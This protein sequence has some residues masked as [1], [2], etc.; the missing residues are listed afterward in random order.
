MYRRNLLKSLLALGGL[1]LSIIPLKARSVGASVVEPVVTHTLNN[2]DWLNETYVYR[3]F[4]VGWTGW[5]PS[6]HDFSIGGSKLVGQWIA[7]KHGSHPIWIYSS[8]PGASGVYK[9]GD[10]FD[11]TRKPWQFGTYVF[12]NRF[13]NILEFEK[14]KAKEIIELEIDFYLQPK[15]VFYYRKN[16]NTFTIQE[17]G[18]RVQH[19]LEGVE[20][21]SSV[22][23]CY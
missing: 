22:L 21:Y 1:G 10:I 20:D 7:Y 2:N 12:N 23:K 5:K 17:Q 16:G 15:S 19:I 13:P 9:K 18:S 4:T 8:A 14:K 11:I 6:V 3:G